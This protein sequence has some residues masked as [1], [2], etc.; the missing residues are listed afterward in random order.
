MYGDYWGL[1]QLPFENTPDP[2]F[3]FQSPH[4]QEGLARLTYVIEGR[5]G[6]G[7]LTGVFG[8]GKTLLARALLG[9]LS[10]SRYRMVYIGNPLMSEVELLHGI[11]TKLNVPDLPDRRSDLLTDVLLDAMGRTLQDNMRD[12]KDTLIIVD[13]A[14]VIRDARVLEELRLL[15]NFQEED[16]FL[17]TLILMGQPELKELVDRDK[18][19]SQ[20]MCLGYH[21]VPL[22]E[23]ETG[24]YLKHRLSVAGA[25]DPGSIFAKRAVKLLFEHSA[26]IPR[27][28][29][30][31]ADLAMVSGMGKKL[32]QIDDAVIK[33]AVAS[34]GV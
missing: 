22:T 18:P 4:H 19:L 16:R 29:N 20:R 33:D 9:Q 2:R 11:A 6:A 23:P 3:L 31:L 7:L 34:L 12:G 1:S 15:L 24:A 13:E 17:L 8:C 28:I 26:G 25:K 14:H 32:K 30:Q 27:R 10:P 5:K 21:L